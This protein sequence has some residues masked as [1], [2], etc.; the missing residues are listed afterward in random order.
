VPSRSFPA[1]DQ[2]I[3]WHNDRPYLEHPLSPGKVTQLGARITVGDVTDGSGQARIV[4]AE[5]KNLVSTLGCTTGTVV[6][7][8]EIVVEGISQGFT[9]DVDPETEGPAPMSVMVDGGPIITLSLG[10]RGTIEFVNNDP[11]QNIDDLLA[12]IRQIM[13]HGVTEDIRVGTFRVV[14]R[15]SMAT[16]DG[17]KSIGY[18]SSWRVTGD[19]SELVEYSPY[20]SP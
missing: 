19:E 12:T 15:H 13:E 5:L 7:T 10:K 20:V 4:D 17:R 18:A 9:I 11:V 6:T 1:C 16:P 2:I 14:A 8:E 3:A